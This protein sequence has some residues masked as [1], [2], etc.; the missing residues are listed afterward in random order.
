MHSRKKSS[1]LKKQ[2]QKHEM[3]FLLWGPLWGMKSDEP[4]RRT[5]PAPHRE[6]QAK[7]LRA[8]TL[9]SK[10]LDE[11]YNPDISTNCHGT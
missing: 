3:E 6:R 1:Y 7:K 10:I 2:N 4:R 5:A 9:F 8:R 11:P